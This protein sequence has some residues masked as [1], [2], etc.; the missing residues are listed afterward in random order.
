MLTV[1]AVPVSATTVS[2][3][4]EQEYRDALDDLSS[5]ITV[6]PHVID[7]TA[8]FTITLAGDPTYTGTQPLTIEGN[9]HTIDGGGT[10]SILFHNTGQALAINNLTLTNGKSTGGN[11]GGAILSAQGSVTVTGSTFTNNTAGGSG[12]AISSGR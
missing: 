12:G 7:L 9:G 1:T 3:A 11:S 2:V 8:G 10:H 5:D 6:G 4:T